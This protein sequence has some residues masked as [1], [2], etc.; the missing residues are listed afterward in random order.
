MPTEQ[1]EP[2]QKPENTAVEVA[3]RKQRAW[4][5]VPMWFYILK[6]QFTKRWSS[7]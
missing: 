5:S 2:G 7:L 1:P 3:V 4:E 6:D